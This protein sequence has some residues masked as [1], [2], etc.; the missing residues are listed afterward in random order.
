MSSPRILDGLYLKKVT[1]K[2]YGVFSR[3]P[4]QRGA[5]IEVCAWIPVNKSTQIFLTRNHNQVASKLFVNGDALEKE[6]ELVSKLTD[7]EIQNRLDRGLLTPHQVKQLLSEMI[8]PEQMLLMDSHAILMGYGSAYRQSD[9]P[10]VAWE[11]DKTTKLYNFYTVE[12]VRADQELTYL[13]N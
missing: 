11:Y 1:D 8:K 9:R 12:E 3:A 10:N 4:I 2:D 6:M 13:T 5:L 7:L